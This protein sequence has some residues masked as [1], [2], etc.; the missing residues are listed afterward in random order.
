MNQ[1]GGYELIKP[2]QYPDLNGLRT[3]MDQL[4]HLLKKITGKQKT[5]Q[6]SDSKIN[7]FGFSGLSII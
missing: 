5:F 4:N 1:T 3:Q 7:Q 6:L 2:E